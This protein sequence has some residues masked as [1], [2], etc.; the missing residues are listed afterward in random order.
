M[1][2]SILRFSKRL[3]LQEKILAPYFFNKNCRPVLIRNFYTILLGLK[4]STPEAHA[5]RHGFPMNGRH[6]VCRTRQYVHHSTSFFELLH[7]H[8][9]I[10]VSNQQ[11]PHFCRSRLSHRTIPHQPTVL[12][13]CVTTMCKHLDHY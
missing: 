4:M 13:Q 2:Y 5:Q 7:H 12:Q 11:H 9:P 3:L 10:H 8:P 1:L 6:Y